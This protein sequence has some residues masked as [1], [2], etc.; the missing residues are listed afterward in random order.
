MDPGSS[1]TADDG[2]KRKEK[3]K[4]DEIGRMGRSKQ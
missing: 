1:W 3:E 2:R 4:I